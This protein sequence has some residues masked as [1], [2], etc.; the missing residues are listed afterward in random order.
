M[1][2]KMKADKEFFDSEGYTSITK[3]PNIEQTDIK[4]RVQ[5]FLDNGIR[6]SKIIR[7]CLDKKIFDVG[8]KNPEEFATVRT[9]N[10]SKNLNAKELAIRM[11]IARE[12]KPDVLSDI[13]AFRRFVANYGI[14][15][16]N[17][18][19][20]LKNTINDFI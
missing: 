12:V 19:E 14:T 4:T 20:E 5:G 16:E 6:D 15:K 7:Q 2:A 13:L 3:D 17:D 8:I 11:K 9:R 18:A 10:S 1:Y